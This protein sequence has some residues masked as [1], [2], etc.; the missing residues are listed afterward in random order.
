MRV[1]KERERKRERRREMMGREI[2]FS[3]SHARMHAHTRVNFMFE[4]RMNA[5]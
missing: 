4:T 3:L 2:D 5:T 1:V